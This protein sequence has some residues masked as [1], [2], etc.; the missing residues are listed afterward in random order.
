MPNFARECA[1]TIMWLI[2]TS[3]DNYVHSSGRKTKLLLRTKIYHYGN[4]TTG[5]TSDGFPL[6]TIHSN[7][8]K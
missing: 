2:T 1:S 6:T 5:T 3:Y 7:E 8:N 4:A